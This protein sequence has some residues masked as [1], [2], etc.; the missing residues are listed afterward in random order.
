MYLTWTTED[1]IFFLDGLGLE[2]RTDFT[3][4]QL[5]KK[6]KDAMELRANWG[7]IEKDKIEAWL[8]ERGVK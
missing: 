6:Y 1:E 3:P 2:F 5:L 4:S 7:C 8:A